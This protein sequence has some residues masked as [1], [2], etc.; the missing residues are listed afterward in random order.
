MG[1]SREE[2]QGLHFDPLATERAK[3]RTQQLQ[4]QAHVG[5]VISEL[6]VDPKWEMYARHVNALKEAADAWLET[7]RNKVMEADPQSLFMARIAHAKA[8]ERS[9]TLKEALDLVTELVKT[10][11]IAA[12]QLDG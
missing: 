3:I 12:E 6:L 8:L 4:H 11:R 9:R 10:G 7:T 1:L 5:K 2:M